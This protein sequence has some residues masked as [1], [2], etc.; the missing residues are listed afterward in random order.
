MGFCLHPISRDLTPPTSSNFLP[1]P[2]P[3][4]LCVIPPLPPTPTSLIASK[5]PPSP[6]WVTQSVRELE[7][8]SRLFDE[9]GLLPATPHNKV[10]PGGRMAGV[11]CTVCARRMREWPRGMNLSAWACWAHGADQANTTLESCRWPQVWLYLLLVTIRLPSTPPPFLTPVS[12]SHPPPLMALL[13][14]PPGPDQHPCGR[15]VWGRQEDNTQALRRREGVELGVAWGWLDGVGVV[16]GL[17]D[18]TGLLC[19]TLRPSTR[20][21]EM[22]RLERW[23]LHCT[24]RRPT[25]PCLPAEVPRLLRPLDRL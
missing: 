7:V 19:N 23:P 8:H 16:W 18:R 12:H 21:L 6:R 15:H 3:L 5:L 4:P 1:L 11:R 14:H 17:V 13:P 22:T 20:C 25:H 10:G 9:M 24:P 2:L